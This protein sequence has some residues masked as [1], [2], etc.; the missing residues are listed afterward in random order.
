VPERGSVNEGVVLAARTIGALCTCESESIMRFFSSEACSKDTTSC[1][2]L[3]YPDALVVASR[4]AETFEYVFATEK[5]CDASRDLV[6]CYTEAGEEVDRKRYE[7]SMTT[8]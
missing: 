7:G 3:R 5:D 8:V 2:L 4:R 6:V 1:L